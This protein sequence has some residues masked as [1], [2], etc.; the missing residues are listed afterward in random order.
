MSIAKRICSYLP[1]IGAAFLS[2]MANAAD[3]DA[4]SQLTKRNAEF[5]KEIIRVSDSVYT[6]V[7]YAVSPVSMIVGTDGVIIVDTGVDAVSGKAI[8]EDFRHIVDKPVKAIIFSHG[9]GDHI[10]GASAFLDTPDVQIWARENF[11]HEQRFLED[12]GINIQRRRG[13]MQAGFLLSPEERINNGVAKAYWPNQGDAVFKAG[14]KVEPTHQFNNGRKKLTLAGI[15]IELVAVSGETHD[16]LY[17]WFPS[18]RVAFSGDNFYKSWPNLYAIR[19]SAYRDVKEWANAIDRIL[20]EKP[21]AVVGG[22]TRPIIGGQQVSE[23]LTNFRDAIRFLFDKTVEGINLGMTPNQLVD[24]VVLPEKYQNLDYL[25]PYYGNPAWAVRSIFNGYLGWFD[26]NA[27]N[28]F[29]LNDREEAK[30]IADIAGGVEALLVLVETALQ[31]DDFQW[32][33]QLSDYVLALEPNSEAALLG[34]AKALTHLAEGVLTT[35]ARNYFLSS[36][37]QLRKKADSQTSGD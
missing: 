1:V 4:S 11:G 36:A 21:D 26:G 13:A 3:L 12:A 23:T 37:I 10:G 20:K 16:H 15:D 35:T 34:K 18:E 31:E 29:P 7:G 5:E 27:S 8:R 28:L 17:V 6:A 2:V 19:G 33:V 22:H 9:H 30:R 25:Q 32:V 14:H 24:Y